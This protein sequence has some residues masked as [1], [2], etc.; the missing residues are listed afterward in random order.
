MKKIVENFNALCA[1]F[2]ECRYI[3]LFS[4]RGFSDIIVELSRSN[5][6]D[7]MD[8]GIKRATKTVNSFTIGKD[9]EKNL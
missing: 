1:L 5:E 3:F 7:S 4:D 9:S 6:A 2:K 8:F